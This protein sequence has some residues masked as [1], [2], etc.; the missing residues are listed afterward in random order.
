MAIQPFAGCGRCLDCQRG[1]LALCPDGLALGANRD[2]L[3]Q[4]QVVLAPA[5]LRPLDV[6]ADPLTAVLAD[7]LATALHAL[8]A[9]EEPG[10]K[11]VAVLGGGAVG[12]C[13]AWVLNDTGAHVSLVARHAAVRRNLDNVLGLRCLPDGEPPAGDRE[14]FDVVFDC[15]GRDDVSLRQCLLLVRAGGT[16]VEVG[17]H[18]PGVC[19]RLPLRRVFGRELRLVGSRAYSVAYPADELSQALTLLSGRGKQLKSLVTHVLPYSHWEEGL[20]LARRRSKSGAVKVVFSF[21]PET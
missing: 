7:P 19:G 8:H 13:L 10:G 20:S 6:G 18:L 16:I 2:G 11:R 21:E 15:V 1:A 17:M 12:A 4:P 9:V 3:F 14:V 5:L